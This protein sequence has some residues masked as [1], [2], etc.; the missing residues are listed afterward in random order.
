MRCSGRNL[1]TDRRSRLSDTVI[2]AIECLK[3]WRKSDLLNETELQNVDRMLHNLE[4]R[5]IRISK[6]QAD[7]SGGSS[8]I[9]GIESDTTSDI[10]LV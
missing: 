2:E 9:T 7:W 10:P 6:S 1:I 3:A 4:E 5:S 8:I